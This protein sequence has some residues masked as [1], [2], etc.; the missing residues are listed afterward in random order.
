MTV[1]KIEKATNGTDSKWSSKR[2]RGEKIYLVTFPGYAKLKPQREDIMNDL[3]ISDYDL[4]DILSGADDF[5]VQ[6]RTVEGIT[7][8]DYDILSY[9]TNV[10]ASVAADGGRLYAWFCWIPSGKW[11]QDES[12]A[13][14]LRESFGVIRR[15]TEDEAKATIEY[16]KRS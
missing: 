7:Y 16:Y 4:Q 12:L 14:E 11:D 2:S 15:G 6:E 8:V 9:K 13:R 3:A 10:L 1:N 5:R